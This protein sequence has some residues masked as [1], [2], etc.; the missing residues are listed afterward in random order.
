[1]AAPKLMSAHEYFAID[2]ASEVKHE[3][4]EG[5]IWAMAAGTP[6]HAQL[7]ARIGGLLF[8]SVRRKQCQS[9]SSDLRVALSRNTYAYP[10]HTIICGKIETLEDNDKTVTNP[11]VVFEVLSP[12]TENYDLGRKAM[13]YRRIESLR[14]LVLVGSEEVLVVVRERQANGSWVTSEFSRLDQT[15]PLNSIAAELPLADLYEGIL[16]G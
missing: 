12:A 1:M 7:S 5:K 16:E 10:D 4:V 14:A 11:T 3:L 9:F 15:V 13:L 8:P 6:V 2:E